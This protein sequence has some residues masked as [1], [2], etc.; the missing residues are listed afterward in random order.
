METTGGLVLEDHLVVVVLVNVQGDAG[1]P[2]RHL[3]GVQVGDCGLSRLPGEPGTAQDL[4]NR[5]C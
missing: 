1:A 2:V 4:G 5:A 3:G